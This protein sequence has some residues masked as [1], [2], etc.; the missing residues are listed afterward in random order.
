MSAVGLTS[1]H[2]GAVDWAVSPRQVSDRWVRRRIGTIWMLLFF[3]GLG[4]SPIDTLLRIPR[5]I[6][7]GMTAAAVFVA[8]LLALSLNRRLLFRP[9]FVLGLSTALLGVAVVGG[10][11]STDAGVGTEW[12]SLRYGLVLAVL[13]LL[14]PWWGREDLLLARCH[15]RA[16]VVVSAMTIVGLLLV[17][18]RALPE[19]RLTGIVWPV[20]A[21]Q[22][23]EYAALAGGMGIVLWLC[24][25]MGHIAALGF[26]LLGLGLVA[27]TQTRTALVACAGGV[28]VAAVTHFA[29]SRR[30]RRVAI[31]SVILAPMLAGAL[32]SEVSAWI[33]R[34]Q[35][36]AQINDLTG[37]R[38]VWTALLATPRSGANQ[39]IGFGLSNKSFA[40][41]GTNSIQVG[42]PIDNDWLAVYQDEG[43]AGDILVA[44]IMLVLLFT[45]AFRPASPARA[46]AVFLAVY[47]TI[48]SYTEVGLGDASPYLLHGVV[49]ASLLVP[50]IRWKGVSQ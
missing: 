28:V 34:G 27:L 22:V 18:G 23:A 42:H 15:L 32:S 47:C 49:A 31:V 33:T 41:P 3:N 5:R 39:W 11:F 21:P 50:A 20:P 6:E 19:G 17:P 1:E 9:N 37:R 29:A 44:L 46:L 4:S 7:Q 24:G 26:A 40:M 25:R 45:P 38:D 30:I 36:A 16:L 8:L 35:S 13:W 43:L 10:A 14:T 48:A 12:R 2:V